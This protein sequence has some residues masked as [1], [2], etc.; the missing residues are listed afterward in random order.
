MPL[1]S[2]GGFDDLG[3]GDEEL[4]LACASHGGEPEHIAIVSRMLDSI[5]REEGDLACGPESH[6]P[7]VGHQHDALNLEPLQLSD[8][9][10]TGTTANQDGRGNVEG[11]R[12]GY[13]LDS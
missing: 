7:C 12:H 3:W 8:D 2:S 9:F 4:V 11:T 13:P 10:A 5:D 1:L 6:H